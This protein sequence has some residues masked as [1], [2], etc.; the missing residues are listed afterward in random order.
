MTGHGSF[1]FPLC[2]ARRQK[3]ILTQIARVRFTL[4]DIYNMSWEYEERLDGSGGWRTCWHLQRNMAAE[5]NYKSCTI[6]SNI[7]ACHQRRRRCLTSSHLFLTVS[8]RMVECEM[9]RKFCGDDFELLAKCES[10]Y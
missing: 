2:T 10:Y 9:L 6:C 3:S 1:T 4:Y 8:V 7:L 5:G